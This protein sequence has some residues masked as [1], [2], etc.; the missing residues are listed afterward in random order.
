MQNSKS[1]AVNSAI[2]GI[3]GLLLAVCVIT[4]LYLGQIILIP[5]AL[6]IL[7]SFALSH[8]VSRLERWLNRTASVVIVVLMVFTGIGITSYVM[9]QQIID[10]A[11]KLPDYK[12][13]ISAKLRSLRIP[14]E[15][16]LTR[17]SRTIE[18]L[19]NEIPGQAPI[20]PEP[21]AKT[22]QIVE[23]KTD[24]TNLLESFFGG[25]FH[26]LSTS[27]FV[28]LLVFFMLLNREDLRGRMIKLIGQGR[29]SSTTL[30]MDDASNR[31]SHYLYM[32][33]IVNVIFG[34]LFGIGLYLIGIPNAVLWGGLAMILRFI[35]YL[36]VWIAATIPLALSLAVSASW[37]VPLIVV[38]LIIGLELIIYLIEPWLYGSSTG[39]SPMALVVAAVFW[40]WLWGP[41]GLVLST[42]LTVC[43][44]V[45]G[46]H[47]GKLKFLSVLL[48]DEEPLTPDE[49]LYHRLL[50]VDQ[51]ETITFIEGYLKKHTITDLYDT[52]F[53]P[54]ISTAE[55]DLRLG[56]I[57]EDQG[58]I[59]R[60]SIREVV[61]DLS[62]L[63]PTSSETK[64]QPSPIRSCRVLCCPAKEERDELAG[65][66]L[67]Q[68]LRLKSFECEN[69]SAKL[70]VS[71]LIDFTEKDV[72]DVIIISAVMPSSVI[73][74]R[75]LCAKLRLKMPQVKMI[76]GI[77]GSGKI[78]PEALQKL[79]YAGVNEIVFSLNEAVTMVET[80]S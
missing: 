21:S 38:C 1:N 66:M 43:L 77:W 62:S 71:E 33:F 51:N 9:T 68:L 35:P 22:T 14:Q 50:S 46:H 10:L 53:I 57:E 48:S 47:V 75:Y 25:F 11:V 39:V 4:S 72:P 18:E 56:H 59:L 30:A 63:P 13:N 52:I 79:R 15:Y 6:A 45:M 78:L 42:A 23:A 74:V 36:G 40:T 44:V 65:S 70:G 12:T 31:I 16:I 26:V 80:I 28:L 34:T 17:L 24:F 7:L 76:A 3:Y 41:I 54:V 2:I 27:G 73:H 8:V 49:E 19:R 67:A 20:S 61:E 29:I 64:E 5:F 58:I 69:L 55:M 60:Q 32:Q 37:A